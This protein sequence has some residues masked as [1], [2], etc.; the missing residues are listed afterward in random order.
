MSNKTKF[1]VIGIGGYVARKHVKAIYDNGGEIIGSYDLCESVGYLDQYSYHIPF[2]TSYNKFYNT[3]LPE[4]DYLVVCTPN[5]YH[6]EH[7]LSGLNNDKNVICEKPLI[8]HNGHLKAIQ[9]KENELGKKCW[10]ILQSRYNKELIELKNQIKQGR[11]IKNVNVKYITPRGFW[12]N[13]SWKGVEQL[14][15]GLIFNIGIHLLDVMQWL[16]GISAKDQIYIKYSTKEI[17]EGTI[18]SA[19]ITI[20]WLLSIEKTKQP[21]EPI[22]TISADGH[23]IN[24]SEKFTD[25]HSESYRQILQGNGIGTEEAAKSIAIASRIRTLILNNSIYGEI[26]AR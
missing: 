26:N 25:L 5:G 13:E 7:I 14:S 10:T 21:T 1:A 17:I 18:V 8:I 11:V 2:T 4:S 3:Y 9:E 19:N 22:R 24:L 12:Y 16:F 6:Y 23:L 20:D 15:G